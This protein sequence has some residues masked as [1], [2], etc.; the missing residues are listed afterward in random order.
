MKL[1]IVYK[2]GKVVSHRSLLKVLL[3]PILRY[4]GYQI[5]TVYCAE[6]DKLK[7]LKIIKSERILPKWEK[8]NYDYDFI[9]KKRIFL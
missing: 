9:V 6:K 3:N 5:A 1:G 4:F 2:D 8:Y 7:G